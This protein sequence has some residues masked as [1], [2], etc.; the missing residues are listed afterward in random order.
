MPDLNC[1]QLLALL[2]KDNLAGAE[3]L[4]GLR[5]IGLPICNAMPHAFDIFEDQFRTAEGFF[6]VLGLLGGTS[7]LRVHEVAQVRAVVEAMRL[8][9]VSSEA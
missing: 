1:N 8:L 4:G 3:I 7:M 6:T 2:V 5:S 9:D